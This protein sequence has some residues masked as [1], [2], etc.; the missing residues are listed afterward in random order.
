MGDI[1]LI[2]DEASVRKLLSIVLKSAG[3]QVAEASSGKEG[4]RRLREHPFELVITDILMPDMDGLEITRAIHQDFPQVKIVVVS[5]GRQDMGFCNAAR[6]LGAHATLA[7]PVPL[8][9]LLETVSRQLD[10]PDEAPP[11]RSMSSS[12]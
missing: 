8:E 5:G 1:L 12:H 6:Y 10:R 9:L 2:D 7:K 4:V 11:S 3:H